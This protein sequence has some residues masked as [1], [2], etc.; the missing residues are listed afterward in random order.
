M[1]DEILESLE[2]FEVMECPEAFNCIYVWKNKVNGKTYVGKAKKLHERRYRHLIAKDDYY[3]HNSL[4]KR[5]V[6]SYQLAVIVKDV[7]AEE[8][9]NI[10]RYYVK[11]LDSL[12]K[13]GKGYNIAEGGE[14]GNNYAGKKP[15]EMDEINKKKS[16][17][18]AD[19]SGK[20]NP[21][22]RKIILLNTGEVFDYINQAVE[23]YGVNHRHISA[24]CRGK[25]KSAGVIDGKP[26]TWMYF[27]DYEKLSEEEITKIKN[28]E[29]A[30]NGGRPK[31]VICTTTRKTYS[32]VSEASRQTGI[33]PSSISLCCNGKY[34]FA[35]DP[36]TGE[37]LIFMFLDEYLESK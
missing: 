2:W 36:I 9:G 24:C 21:R 4:K 15:E 33:A 18:H 28:Q 20:N 37:K 16:E 27:E 32:S 17:N 6:E 13:N 25:R 22:S 7:P 35:K 19:V 3:L 10:E 8:L 5:G 11:A 34:K 12:R 26:A 1:R 30:N 31:A 29:V 23:K 14:G